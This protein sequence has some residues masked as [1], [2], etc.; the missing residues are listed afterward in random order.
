MARM[1]NR[2]IIDVIVAYRQIGVFDRDL[3]EG[4]PTPNQS[5]GSWLR[6]GTASVLLALGEDVGPSLFTLELWDVEPSP[7]D[8]L[9]WS[10]SEVVDLEFPS[11]WLCV[12]MLS[13][14]SLSDVFNVGAP[15][16]YSA[17]FAW[18]ENPDWIDPDSEGP[19]AFLVAQFWQKAT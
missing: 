11:G 16:R 7:L 18:R 9:D 2:A 15:G 3:Y 12:E 8:H 10:V 6:A 14:G 13:G 4:L 19:E 1:L 5:K 17:R